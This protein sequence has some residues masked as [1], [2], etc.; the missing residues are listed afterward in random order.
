MLIWRQHTL[1]Q[2]SVIALCLISLVLTIGLA[3]TLILL[4]QKET[5]LQIKTNQ[6]STLN[7]EKSDLAS[8][9]SNIQSEVS[10]L[11]NG[12]SVLETEKSTLENQVTVLQTNITNLQND[13]TTLEHEKNALEMQIFPLQSEISSLQNGVSVL[14]T[15]KSTLE[16]QV[17]VLQ[18]NITNLQNDVTTLEVDKDA[19]E[20][21]VS[22]LQNGVE[23]LETQV[24]SLEYEK[25]SLELQVAGLVTQMANLEAEVIIRYD[26]G[27][28]Q[29]TEDLIQT[30][31]YFRDP[32]F[33]E[34]ITF[35]ESD[36]TD[37]NLYTPEYVCYDFTADLISNA[38]QLGYNSGFVYIE[39]ASSAH[40]IA[41][42]ETTDAGL[43]FV[44][45]QND[46]LVDVAVGQFYLGKIIVKMGII[47]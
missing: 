25:D 19:L 34:V 31:Y 42:F 20:Q 35:I 9:V 4:D 38:A 24:E 26:E 27:Y 6:I 36:E 2:K 44:E 1:V 22:I 28:A 10:S 14:E 46:E 15:E 43:I 40:A 23:N 30:G 13:V 3:G 12:V 29:G 47:W 39:F 5:E 11:Q 45:P 7:T 8:Y 17:T 18:T 16:N 32:T 37:E 41:C 33:I 21:Q